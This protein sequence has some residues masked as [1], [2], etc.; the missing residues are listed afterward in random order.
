M[1][2][3]SMVDSI[4]GPPPG[5]GIG[6]YLG[7]GSGG[8]VGFGGGGSLSGISAQANYNTGTQEYRVGT[9]RIY[10]QAGSV[11]WIV[12]DERDASSH[13][14]GSLEEALV[15]TGNLVSSNQSE[16]IALRGRI[17]ELESQLS[18]KYEQDLKNIRSEVAE[19]VDLMLAEFVHNSTIGQLGSEVETAVRSHLQAAIGRLSYE[20]QPICGGGAW[21]HLA[22]QSMAP[23]IA[24]LLVALR[25]GGKSVDVVAEVMKIVKAQAVQAA[26]LI[27]IM[28]GKDG[29]GSGE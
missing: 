15:I 1:N 3:R 25:S 9:F 10:P 4:F 12:G 2:W 24:T 5:L 17:S 29:A 8:G 19:P 16:V 23:G 14:C 13:L 27:D 28:D 26:A 11:C 6:A 20:Q 22:V 21:G 18:K 7:S